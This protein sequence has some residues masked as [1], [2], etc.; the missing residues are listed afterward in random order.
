MLDIEHLSAQPP[1]FNDFPAHQERNMSFEFSDILCENYTNNTACIKRSMSTEMNYY[2]D[3]VFSGSITKQPMSRTCS[4]S[5]ED[6]QVEPLGD[7]H[8]NST[9]QSESELNSMK[10]LN[11]CNS[12]RIC[13]NNEMLC[14]STNRTCNNIERLCNTNEQMCTNSENES[15]QRYY[16]VS[17]SESPDVTC[18]WRNKHPENWDSQDVLDWLFYTAEKCNL[19]CSKLRAENFRSTSGADLCNF[20]IEDFERIESE[21]GRTLYLLFKDMRE[22]LQFTKPQEL[23]TEY[24][25]LDDV[26][27]S[28]RS[29]K[30][31]FHMNSDPGFYPYP[32]NNLPEPAR[33]REDIK[34]ERGPYDFHPGFRYPSQQLQPMHDFHPP[35]SPSHHHRM[36]PCLPSSNQMLRRFPTNLAHPL[37]RCSM[38]ENSQAPPIQ[39]RRPGRPR[40]KSLPSD[41]EAQREKKVKNQHLWEFIYE[42]LMNPLYNP[43]Y[44]RWENQREGVF[45]FVQSEAVAQLWGS[46]KNNDNMTYEK[47]SRAMRHYYKRGILE[48]VEGRRL[49]YKFSRVAMDRVREKRHSVA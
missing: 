33:F 1:Y 37:N 19:D 45:R 38:H 17:P 3:N 42:V 20:S 36:N 11:V 31:F 9:C 21:Y 29:Q 48:R 26:F 32:N 16:N 2:P 4:M 22:G 23:P 12:D 13:H 18:R 44:V 10:Q 24:M 15:G 25:D 35:F 46:L 6:N 5:S 41:E 30:T 39:R 49:V 27:D 40:I 34:V 28:K 7:V 8:F 14:N 43:Q 47:L